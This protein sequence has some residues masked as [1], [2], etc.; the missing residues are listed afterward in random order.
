MLIKDLFKEKKFPKW[1]VN[2]PIFK[3]TDKISKV[4]PGIGLPN[5]FSEI[6]IDNTKAAKKA[7]IGMLSSINDEIKNNTES[8]SSVLDGKTLISSRETIGSGLIKKIYTK[9]VKKKTAKHIC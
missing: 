9:L 3:E 1:F 8:L 5:S 4:F 2:H 6:A 7:A